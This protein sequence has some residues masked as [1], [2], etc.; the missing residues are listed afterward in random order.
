MPFGN[1]RSLTDD[2][3][4]A[5]TAYLL[6]LNDIVKDE[7]FELNDKN[8]TSIKLPNAAAFYDDDREVSEKQFWKKDPCMKNCRDEPKVIGRAMSL[9]VTPDNKEGPK[10]E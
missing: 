8:F 6:S 10:V 5:I 9:D 7:N 3:A 1:A 4:Y 2:E